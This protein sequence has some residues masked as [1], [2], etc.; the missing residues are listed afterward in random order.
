LI[1]LTI[2]ICA[3]NE[4]WNIGEL[5]TNI[6]SI[7]GIPKDA[8]VIAVCSGCQD[9]TA[10]VVREFARRDRRVKLIEEPRRLGKAAAVKANK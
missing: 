10:E 5:L 9:G 6:L 7:Q 3:Y 8:E 1:P 4:E 2:G